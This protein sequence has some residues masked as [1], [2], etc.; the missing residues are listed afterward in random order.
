[1]SS[2]QRPAMNT[3]FGERG[4]RAGHLETTWRTTRSA[5]CLPR[6]DAAPRSAL[7]WPP[8]D[9]SLFVC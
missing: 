3:A 8:E 1:M 5:Q 9:R 6:N 4:Q 2:T 7:P